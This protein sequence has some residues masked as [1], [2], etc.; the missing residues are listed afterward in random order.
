MGDDNR[1]SAALP[2]RQQVKQLKETVRQQEQRFNE[3][4]QQQRQSV[5][6]RGVPVQS[7]SSMVVLSRDDIS[8][9]VPLGDGSVSTV[10]SAV[11]NQ[12]GRRIPVAIKM[13]RSSSSRA[14][15][16]LFRS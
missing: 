12:G 15:G 6:V 11:L 13:P 4:Q 1:E 3:F 2:L 7:D 16:S 10:Y 9:M 14:A 5:A 8:S